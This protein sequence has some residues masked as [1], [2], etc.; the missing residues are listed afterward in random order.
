MTDAFALTINDIPF[1]FLPYQAEVLA[2]GP[3]NIERGEIKLNK[4]LVHDG[5][6]EYT[7]ETIVE[8]VARQDKPTEVIY[9]GDNFKCSSSEIVNSFFEDLG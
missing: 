9:I 5:F 3:R 1:P 7:A 6:T 8:W 2:Q 4:R